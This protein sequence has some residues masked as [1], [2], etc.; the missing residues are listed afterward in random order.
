MIGLDARRASSLRR[1]SRSEVAALP[2]A[3]TKKDNLLQQQGGKNLKLPNGRVDG[4]QRL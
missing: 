4:A 3:D 2:Q 1:G